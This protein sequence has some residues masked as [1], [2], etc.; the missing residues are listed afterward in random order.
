MT[1]EAYL[2]RVL[3]PAMITVAGT[4]FAVARIVAGA[5]VAAVIVSIALRHSRRM[6]SPRLRLRSV[7]QLSHIYRS[8]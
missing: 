6:V 3:E 4:L 5:L 2:Y 1:P 7:Q 8:L